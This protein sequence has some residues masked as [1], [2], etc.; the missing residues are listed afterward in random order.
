MEEEDDYMDEFNQVERQRSDFIASCDTAYRGILI[1]GFDEWFDQ[2]LYQTKYTNLYEAKAKI[3][4]NLIKYYESTEEYE[5]CEFLK[6]NLDRVVDEKK[7]DPLL[8]DH[9]AEFFDWTQSGST[10]CGLRQ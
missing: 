8:M 10:G 6:S 2:F 1:I 3:V 9:D 5:R 7:S 4:E